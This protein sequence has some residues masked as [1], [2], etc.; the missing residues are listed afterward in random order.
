[1]PTHRSNSR[2]AASPSRN[3]VQNSAPETSETAST[4]AT[5]HAEA[6]KQSAASAKHSEGPRGAAGHSATWV[7]STC[8]YMCERAKTF[9]TKFA[10][11]D[12][13]AEHAVRPLAA[14]TPWQDFL[15]LEVVD[16]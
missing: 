10:Q 3:L 13:I 16:R 8:G 12:N 11:A 6:S 14:G 15:K 9:H 7:C 2:N 5:L 4:T 1:M